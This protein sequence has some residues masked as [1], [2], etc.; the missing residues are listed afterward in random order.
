MANSY[1][2]S[3]P[4]KSAAALHGGPCLAGDCSPNSVSTVL[5][6]RSWVVH[7]PGMRPRDMYRCDSHCGPW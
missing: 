3:I 7:R 6:V 4:T 1:L 5:Y 2:D